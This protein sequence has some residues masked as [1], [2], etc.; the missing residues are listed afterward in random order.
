VAI[1]E[2]SLHK[3]WGDGVHWWHTSEQSAEVFS[4][5]IVFSTNSRKFSPSKVFHYVLVGD[6]SV[7]K[8][9]RKEEN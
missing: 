4:M 9:K 8:C 6:L 3:I 2:S 7:R 1:C 5:K